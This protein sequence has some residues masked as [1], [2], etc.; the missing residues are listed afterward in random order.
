VGNSG[1]ILRLDAPDL[2]AL[3]T[4]SDTEGV[5]NALA[6][7]G[8]AEPAIGAPLQRL[9]ALE[10]ARDEHKG[11]IRREEKEL[12]HV[13]A[14]LP[15]LVSPRT[16]PLEVF[17]FIARFS[18]AIVLC[19]LVSVLVS[20]YRYTLRLAA[21]YDARADAVALANAS[22]DHDFHQLVR[23]FTSLGVDFGK[24][25]RSPAEQV[26]DAARGMVR[27]RETQ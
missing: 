25:D 16:D 4:A 20:L 5:T 11:Q 2:T 10:A 13:K 18:Y 26:L 22:L 17:I 3:S 19:F 6:A 9:R 12:E 21:H 14:G 27:R 24:L 1:T 7:L 15:S 23:T 8:I